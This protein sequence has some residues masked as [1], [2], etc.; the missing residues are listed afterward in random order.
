[1]KLEV[2]DASGRVVARPVDAFKPAGRFSAALE[3]SGLAPGVYLARLSALGSTK[4]TKLVLT[5]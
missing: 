4:A 1:V 5:D 3:A 2:L